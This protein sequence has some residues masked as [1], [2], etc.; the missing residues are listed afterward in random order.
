MPDP[1]KNDAPP[2]VTSDTT[3]TPDCAQPL[4]PPGEL[5]SAPLLPT[6]RVSASYEAADVNGDFKN[7]V[8]FDV[9]RIRALSRSLFFKSTIG[10]VYPPIAKLQPDIKNL[11]Q[12]LVIAPVF[13]G[14]LSL[15]T[16]G[17]DYQYVNAGLSLHI[18][19]QDLIATYIDARVQA[20]RIDGKF[21]VSGKIDLGAEIRLLGHPFIMGF[22]EYAPALTT[23]HIGQDD[24]FDGSIDRKAKNLYHFWDVFDAQS[25]TVGIRTRLP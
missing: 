21:N 10:K 19:T 15:S 24:I 13:A 1:I 6:W 7:I 4:A 12:P 9:R 5:E 3:E 23:F 14:G 17:S 2:A 18:N 25:F 11:P 22:I 8:R 20:D 16:E